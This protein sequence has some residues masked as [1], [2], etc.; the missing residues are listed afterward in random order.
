M[1]T[2]EYSEEHLSEYC[3]YCCDTVADNLQTVNSIRQFEREYNEKSPIWCYSYYRFLYLMLNRSLRI[4]DGDIIQR[5]GFFITALHRNIEQLH[6]D[7]YLDNSCQQPFTVY[8]GQALSKTKFNQLKKAKH[9]LISFN[10]FLSTSTDSRVALIFGE[11]NAINPDD[12]GIIYV[13][14]IDPTHTTTPFA[15]IQKISNFFEENEILFSMHSIFRIHDIEPINHIDKLYKVHL[16]LTT[17]NDQD[18]HNLTQYIKHHSY[19]DLQSCYAL[20]QLLIHIGQQNAAEHLCQSLLRNTN[21]KDD[22]VFSTYII[23]SLL[24]RIKEAQGNYNEALGFY[25]NSLTNVAQLLPPNPSSLA[26]SYANIGS[27]HQV[28]GNYSQ[29]LEYNEKAFSIRTE[30]LPPNHPDLA[31]SYINIG[32]VH[33]ARNNYSQA[34]EYHEKALS[35]QTESL[36]PNHTGSAKSYTSIGAVRHDMGNYSQALQ[37]LEKALSIRTESLPPNHPD[38]AASY[39]NIGVMHREM[40]NYSKAL[41]YHE[42][43]LSILTQTLPPNHPS[44]PTSYANIGLVHHD[45]GNYS[46]ALEYHEKALSIRTE[47]VPPNHPDLATSYTNIGVMHCEM[48]NY[49]KALKYNEKALSIR[50][51][52]LPP[53][54]PSFATCY[55]N[56]GLVHHKMGNYSQ[57]LQ[58][59]EKALC[60]RKESLPPNRPNLAASYVRIGL[61]LEM[62]GH[63]SRARYYYRKGLEIWVAILPLVD[64]RIIWIAEKLGYVYM[65]EGKHGRVLAFCAAVSVPMEKWR[66]RGKRPE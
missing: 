48:G 52:S 64:I 57:A 30:S 25:Q 40:G 9:G 18:L 23:S 13:M 46:K 5:M 22:R 31:A 29:A 17:D 21:R 4:L 39:I 47:S 63:V 45:M 1:L 60:I 33:H 38:L 62:N 28:M 44:F 27:M 65:K 51:E 3:N 16:S 12:V 14:E 35:I 8:R 53:N 2:I 37:Y 55:T 58:Y 32:L 19:T 26:A 10:S 54:H 61:I 59:L 20:P 7:Q 42:K 49:S 66:C 50:T 41:E 11:S 36:P 6:K 56:I 34:L 15:S 43:A 24:G